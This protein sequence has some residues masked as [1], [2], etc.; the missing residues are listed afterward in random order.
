MS[1]LGPEQQGLV[2]ALDAEYAAVFAYGVVAAFSNSSRAELVASNTAAHRA[3]RDATIDALQAA[4]VAVPEPAAAYAVPFPVT[5]AVS[6]A[7]LAVQ[8]ETDT[9]VAWRS[10]IERSQSGAARE[11][12]VQALTESAVRLATWQQ[13]LGVT[14]SSTAFPGQP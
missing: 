3:R 11:M 5:D 4:S 10:L 7:R 6:A 1:D 12:G 2:D 13:I 14:P 8:A 9:S